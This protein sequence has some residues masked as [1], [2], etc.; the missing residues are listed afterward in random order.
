V[1]LNFIFSSG[2]RRGGK[3]LKAKT[4]ESAL[5]RMSNMFMGTLTVKGPKASTALGDIKSV[6][7]ICTAFPT[8]KPDL[9]QK[10]DKLFYFDQTYF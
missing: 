4:I 1:I 9:S 8:I 2:S 7:N 5:A 3:N 6:L 10:Q